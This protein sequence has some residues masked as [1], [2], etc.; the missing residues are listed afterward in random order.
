MENTE[1][2]EVNYDSIRKNGKSLLEYN[3]NSIEIHWE[4]LESYNYNYTSL[5]KTM[6]KICW[7][8]KSTDMVQ[9]PWYH[10]PRMV[11][12]T[13]K[14]PTCCIRQVTWVEKCGV[15]WYILNLPFSW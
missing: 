15:P 6:E 10:P 13:S 1:N 7:W 3:Y 12:E 4:K 14:A 2:M 8:Y 5:E 11:K 9:A